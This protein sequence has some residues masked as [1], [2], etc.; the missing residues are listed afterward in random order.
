MK[1]AKEIAEQ[2]ADRLEIDGAHICLEPIITAKLQPLKDALL[3]IATRGLCDLPDVPSVVYRLPAE[4]FDPDTGMMV[5]GETMVSVAED[6]L[7]LL[8]E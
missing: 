3:R 7:A 6:A 1:L 8:E 5:M 4:A 2:C